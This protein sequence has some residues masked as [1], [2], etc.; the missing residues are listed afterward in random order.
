LNNLPKPAGIF[1]QIMKDGRI[2]EREMYR[3]FNMGI[4]LCVMIPK[5]SID[6]AISIFEKWKMKSIVIGNV[7][8]GSG[9]V[10]AAFNSGQ[11]LLTVD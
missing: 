3:T 9:K 8:K 6:G 1:K 7:T 4:G 10:S 2:E 5:S 11:T